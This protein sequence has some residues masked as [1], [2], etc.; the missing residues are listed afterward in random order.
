MTEKSMNEFAAL[1]H[2]DEE[3]ARRFVAAIGGKHEEEGVIAIVEFA[4]ARGFDVAAQDLEKLRLPAAADG[5]LSDEELDAV[6]G[7]GLFLDF[8]NPVNWAKVIEK[9]S[10]VRGAA[11]LVHSVDGAVKGVING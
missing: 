8:I 4:Q 3:M 1:L 2:R 11:G 7:A 6:S 5:A 10:A 9:S